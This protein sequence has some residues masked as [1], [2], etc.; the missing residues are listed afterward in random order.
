MALVTEAFPL[1]VFTKQLE[2]KERKIMEIMEC[3]SKQNGDREFRSIYRYNIT[4][5]DT[6][7]RGLLLRKP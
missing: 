2:N 7:A 3:E 4:E 6:K 1:L 5:T